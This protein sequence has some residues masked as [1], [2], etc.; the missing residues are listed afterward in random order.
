MVR[1]GN[2]LLLSGLLFCGFV[3]P[4]QG[5]ETEDKLVLAARSRVE[6]SE[7]G[8]KFTVV[9]KQLQWKP[10]QTAIIVCD[11]WDQHWCKGATQRAAELAP[12][13]NDAVAKARDKGVL[14]IHAP[15]GTVDYYK[16]HPARKRAADAPKA[17]NLPADIGK[18]CNWVG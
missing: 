15:S 12:R 16:G 3:T 4:A 18:W 11:M 5:G 1:L 13:M 8:G 7:G 14:I 2:T 17:A 10:S 9:C 6:S